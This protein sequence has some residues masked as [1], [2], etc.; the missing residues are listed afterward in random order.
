[1]IEQWPNRQTGSQGGFFSL[2]RFVILSLAAIVALGTA[3]VSRAASITFSNPTPIAIPATGDIG[4]GSPYPS[5]IVVSGVAFTSSTIVIATVF[6]L[7]HTSIADVG[8]LLVG[9]GGQS[10]V[11]MDFV[12][13]G[14]VDDVTYTFAD[15]ASG[16]LPF[17]GAPPS[18]TY[19]P[20]GYD[21]F[22][23]IVAQPD[24]FAPPAPSSGYSGSGMSV[25][26][27]LDPNGI[28]KLYAQ[29]F[30]PVDSGVLAGGWSLTFITAP[31]PESS[32]F[33]LFGAGALLLGLRP[34]GSAR[35]GRMLAHS[36]GT[37]QS[38]DRKGAS[39]S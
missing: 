18:G 27:G 7:T 36:C 32:S 34:R 35:F 2:L 31:V 19:L 13:S 20:T 15:A 3:G 17:V 4:V 21:A 38:R 37:D 25:F 1:M 23:N 8:M 26:Q 9:P 33:F 39:G 6:D 14:E 30:L 16:Y 10:V 11:L 5:P 22:G 29:D 12:G 24:I 28:W